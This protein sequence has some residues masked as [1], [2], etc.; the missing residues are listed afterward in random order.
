[1]HYPHFRLPHPELYQKLFKTVKLINEDIEPDLFVEKG[2]LSLQNYKAFS[3]VLEHRRQAVE[4]FLKTNKEDGFQEILSSSTFNQP[5]NVMGEKNILVLLVDF[6][7]RPGVTGTQ[8]FRDLLFS[9]NKVPTGSLKEYFQEISWDQLS[10]DGDVHGWYR[11]VKDYSHYTDIINLNTQT[12]NWK[13]PNA[14]ELVKEVVIHARDNL[15]ID[16]SKYDNNQD[17]VVD[18]LIVV[19][20]GTGPDI[21][22]DFSLIYPH[23]DKLKNPIKTNDGVEIQDYILMHE[24]PD[25]DLGGFCHEVAH[26]LGLPDLYYP[27]HSCTMVGSWCLMG[28]GDHN[29]HGRTPGH[30]NPWCKIHMGWAVPQLIKGQPQLKNILDIVDPKKDILKVEIQGSNGKEYFLIENRQQT[31]FNRYLPSSG[32]L[33]WHVDEN[34]ASDYFPNCKTPNY[35]ITLEQADGKDELETNVAPYGAGP[36][37]L[38][39][40]DLSGDSGDPY[41]GEV[42]NRSFNDNSLPNSKSQKGTNSCV[43]VTDISNS[44]KVM[45]ARI[46]VD[47]GDK[48]SPVPRNL[49]PLPRDKCTPDLIE[50]TCLDKYQEGYRYGYIK[51]YIEI[52]KRL[53]KP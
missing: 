13:M 16:F 40:I 51:G 25:Y 43:S 44:A 9:T 29:N 39:K 24:L 12:L 50:K 31:G 8:H 21:T 19:Y 14:K 20:A 17:G 5:G 53:K 38:T 28:C 2:G 4:S 52:F 18:T 11:A 30:P 42:N 37:P 32:L 45:Q 10:F 49:T 7:N 33:I 23:Q 1:M 26:T 6:H 22:S 35:F 27:E 36:L 41:P 34:S 15:P 48:K 3:E 47:C 46:G